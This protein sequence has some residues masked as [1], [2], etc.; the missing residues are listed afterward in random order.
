MQRVGSDLQATQCAVK[1]LCFEQCIAEELRS[2]GS[3]VL[4]VT[5]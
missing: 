1:E 2:A 4:A 5:S 3:L